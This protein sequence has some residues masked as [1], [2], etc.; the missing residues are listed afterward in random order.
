[1]LL[2]K[3]V[4]DQV[5]IWKR[6]NGFSDKVVQ[7]YLTMH[8]LVKHVL[9][10]RLVMLLSVR[11]LGVFTSA[12]MMHAEKLIWIPPMKLLACKISGHCFYR[13]LSPSQKEP[14]YA[15]LWLVSLQSNQAPSSQSIKT[16]YKVV[17]QMEQNHSWDHV[18]LG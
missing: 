6:N 10:I 8:V 7:L 3:T 16:F 17:Q 13:L 5:S 1:M 14:D 2:D 11:R 12:V 9:I 18:D 15:L 4:A